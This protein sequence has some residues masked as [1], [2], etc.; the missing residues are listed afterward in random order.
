MIQLTKYEHACFVVEKDGCAL[1]VDPGSFTADLSIPDNVIGIIITHQHA[2][3]FDRELLD[4]I[5]ANNHHAVTIY[6]PADVARK[7]TGYETRVVKH[8]D[9]II[10][11]GFEIDFYGS[12]H[13]TITPETARIDNIG[14]LIDERIYYPGDSFTI[15]EKSVDTLAL[16]AAAPWL[17]VSEAIDFMKSVAPRLV[18]PTHDDILST[19]G[20]NIYDNW[21]SAAADAIDARYQRIDE[22]TITID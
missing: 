10:N 18:F 19:N 12:N 14:V 22:Q 6:A 3:H 11:G 20:K 16:P 17:K 5:I 15:P 13:A 4:A 9:R 7:L 2:D 8:G 21:Y 1:I